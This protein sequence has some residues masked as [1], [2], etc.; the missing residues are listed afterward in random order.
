MD[1]D[2]S[3]PH[4]RGG[5]SDFKPGDILLLTRSYEEY[6]RSRTPDLP[7]RLLNRIAKLE[8]IID[9]KTER[10][11]KIKSARIKSGKWEDLPI[12]ENKFVVSI[13]YPELTGR[14]GQKGVVENTSLFQYDPLTR[15]SFFMKATDE[16]IKSITSSGTYEVDEMIY[17]VPEWVG[18]ELIKKPISFDV[19]L[20][21]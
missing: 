17:H 21:S 14:K 18:R 4:A 20:C 9:W 15:N 13:F 7:I 16:I 11:Q 19:D 6:V 8:D 3:L 5:V 1:N 10:G 12:E 2:F